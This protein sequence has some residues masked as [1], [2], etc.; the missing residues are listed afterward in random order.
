[1]TGGPAPTSAATSPPAS[2]RRRLACMLY[3]ATLLFGVLMVFGLLY[4]GLTQQRHALQGSTGLKLFLF[5]VLGIYFVACWSIGGQTLAMKTWHVRL[6][7]YNGQAVSRLRA[8]A[9]YVLSWLW[10]I[11]ALASAHFSGLKGLGAIAVTL[12]AGMLAYL[13]LA[14]LR[15]DQQFLHDAI[16]ATRLIDIRPDLNQPAQSGA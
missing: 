5:V 7:T 14:K 16:C 8:V 1:M 13:L 6:V 15:P 11:P 12:A 2:L 3:E 4:S 9:R 10:F